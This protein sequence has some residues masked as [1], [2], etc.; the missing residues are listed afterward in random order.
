[1]KEGGRKGEGT[2]GG[3]KRE[4]GRGGVNVIHILMSGTAEAGTGENDRIRLL[5]S[6]IRIVK[7]QPYKHKIIQVYS[8]YSK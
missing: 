5:T 6:F 2:E 3:W 8:C 7:R 4:G 1:M